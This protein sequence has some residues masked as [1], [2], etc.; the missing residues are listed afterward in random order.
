MSNEQREKKTICTRLW[1]YINII[2]IFI[3]YLSTYDSGMDKVEVKILTIIDIHS[4]IKLG[5]RQNLWL[6]D[7]RFCNRSM[8]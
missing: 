1:A 5:M 6:D 8:I 3:I 2:L 7:T 4:M